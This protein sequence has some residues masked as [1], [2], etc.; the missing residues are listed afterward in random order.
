MVTLYY[1]KYQASSKEALKWFRER[2]IEVSVKDIREISAQDLLK[3]LTLSNGF[4]D[5][6]KKTFLK[7]LRKSEQ[8]E[9]LNFDDAF[10]FLL[11]NTDV[12]RTPIILEGKKFL[13]G[14]KPDDIYTFIPKAYR[15]RNKG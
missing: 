6:I 5:V 7:D 15:R 2:K 11:T 13:V 8:F 1:R 4:G 3:V 9:K 14:Y 12:L 10:C